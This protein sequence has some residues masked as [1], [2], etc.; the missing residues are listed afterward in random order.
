[1]ANKL[2]DKQRIWVDTY[3]DAIEEGLSVREA[4]RLAK[5]TAGYAET[6]R[7]R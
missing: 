2:T 4:K 5:E 6:G 3:C 7:H 1:M